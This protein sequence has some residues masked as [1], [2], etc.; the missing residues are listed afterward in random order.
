MLQLTLLM[1][2]LEQILSSGQG[3]PLAW[4]DPAS[5]PDL[6][7]IAFCHFYEQ[8]RV[9]N[10]WHLDQVARSSI[11]RGCSLLREALGP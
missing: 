2:E 3:R 11:E 6:Y 4:R 10:F 5:C 8:D 9:E 1:T 7:A